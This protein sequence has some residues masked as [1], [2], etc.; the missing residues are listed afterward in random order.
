MNRTETAFAAHPTAASKIAA[1]LF[2]LVVSALLAPAGAATADAT[3]WDDQSRSFW[4]DGPGLLLNDEERER[5]LGLDESGRAEWIERF[6]SRDPVS[7]TPE[8]EL[9]VGI[10]K[11]KR[12]VQQTFVSLL[13]DRA[14][15]LFLHGP[16]TQRQPVD[17]DQTFR[18]IE[19]WTYGGTITPRKSEEGSLSLVVYQPKPGSPFRLWLPLDSKRVLYAQEMEY[20]LEQFHE[21]RSQITGRRFDLSLCRWTRAVDRVT[22][23]KGLFDI[24]DDRPSNES[25]ARWLEPPR[26]LGAW[27]RRAIATPELNFAK[28]LDI[29]SVEVAFPKREGQRMTTQLT[30]QLPAGV[31]LEAFTEGEGDPEYRVGVE[32]QIEMNGQPFDQFRVRFKV[33]A[34]T[35]KPIALVLDRPLRPDSQA[36]FRLRVRDE[37]SGATAVLT[38]GVDVPGEPDPTSEIP[39]SEDVVTAIIEDLEV[40]RIAG[41]DGIILVPPTSDVVLGLWR[42][43]TLVT[44]DRISKVEFIVDEKT[45]LTKSRAPFDAEL[46]LAQYPQEQTIRVEGY[47][48]AGELVA[49]DELLINQQRGELRVQISEPRRG[50]MA[51]G[52]VDVRAQ[53]VVPEE[54]RVVEVTFAVNDTVQETRDKP[55]WSATVDVVDAPSEQ[56]LNY[57]TV[58]A[59]LDDGTLAEDV[60]FLNAPNFMEEVEVDLIELY[61]TVVSRSNSIVQG[62]EES[63]F[64]VL[65]DGR[66]QT[67]SR[68]ELVDDLAL[69]IG[70]TIDTSGSMLESLGEARRSAKGFLESIL[71]PRDRSFAVSF[72]NRPALLMTRTSDVAAVTQALDGLRASGS[73]S[74]Y[75]A[76]VTSL[77]YFRG[78]KGRRALVLLSDGEDTASSL[79][80]REALEYAKRSGVAIYSI[81]LNIGRLQAGVRGK[82][83]ELSKETGGRSYFINNADELRAVYGQIE[84]EL[85]SQYLLAYTSD[86]PPGEGDK[87]FRKVEV[88]VKGGAKARTIS[89]YYP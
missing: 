76:V 82:L 66:R 74:L 56:Q 8:N 71:T 12:L 86:R 23:I 59:K 68:F 47:D 84:K 83:Q 50:V 6:L 57:L 19:I 18:P 70:V 2:S 3:L 87:E 7:E 20:W 5:L 25:I 39:I 29:D 15:L 24:Q 17:C 40:S 22:G 77:Y 4:F 73:T 38:Q 45:Q 13:D 85:R 78:V 26:D 60:R 54:R 36:L 58:K 53:V 63:A 80:Y 61:T 43:E 35:E 64:T 10:Q 34:Q 52:Q 89:G 33:E 32:A 9:A 75:D 11:R 48:D 49:A 21:L 37:I 79:S 55:P 31:G 16:P 30:L 62:L 41:S 44:G 65:E 46:R 27:A 72:S 69:S 51:S 14:K 1:L 81:G 28:E 88:K 42:A 67:V